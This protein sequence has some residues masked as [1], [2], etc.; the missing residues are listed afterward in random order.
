VRNKNVGHKSKLWSQKQQIF[1]QN[2]EKKLK[3]IEKWNFTRKMSCYAICGSDLY[4]NSTPD[5]ASLYQR[6]YAFRNRRK[7][8]NENNVE[9]VAKKF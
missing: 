8:A 4:R 9:N 1:D 7:R 6:P 5:N 3:K 2:F